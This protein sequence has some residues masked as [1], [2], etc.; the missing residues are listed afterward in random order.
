MWSTPEQP[1]GAG[2]AL[3]D[4]SRRQFLIGAGA[5]AGTAVAAGGA[6][7]ASG[8][9][10]GGVSPSLPSFAVRS[11]GPVRAFHSR[12]DLRPASISVSNPGAGRDAGYLFLSPRASGGNLPGPLMVDDDGEPVWFRPVSSNPGVSSQWGTNFQPWIYRGQRVLAW[13]EGRVATDGFGQG[14]GILV[15]SSYRGV[16]RVQAAGGRQMD[17]HEFR[18]TPEGTALFTCSPPVTPVDL[19]ALGGSRNGRVQESIFQEVD[20]RTGRLLLEWRSLDHVPVTD[21]YNQLTD[22][23]DYLHINSIDIAPDGHLLVSGRHTW[24]LYKVDRHTGEVIWRLG[25]KRSDYQLGPGARFA[26][27]HDAR[28]ISKSKITL[29]DNG[30]DGA[31]NTEARSRAIVLD[32][33]STRRTAQLA[34][35]YH[36]P[37]PLLA[38]AMGNLQMLPSANVL[39]GWGTEPYVSEFTPGGALLTDARLLSGY[40]SYRAFRLPWRGIPLHSPDITAT[41]DPTTGKATVYASWNGATDVAAYWQVRA[42]ARPTDLRPVGIARRRGFETAIPLGHHARY[43]AATALDEDGSRLAASRAVAV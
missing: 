23:F 35:S 13:W 38:L 6:L 19:S 39:V 17:F 7:A 25:G 40:K 8:L 14:T 24:A 5:I 28:Q 42:G 31:I 1:A 22:P 12:P 30:S 21:S 10:T 37:T 41:R 27:Q 15:D 29:F 16:A 20:I 32:I 43:V 11:S 3:A 9:L 33:D 26:W 36:H 34:K 18:L 4:L 2:Q